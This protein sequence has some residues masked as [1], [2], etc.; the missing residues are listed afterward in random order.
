V[1]SDIVQEEVMEAKGVSYY[2]FP[3]LQ[4]KLYN[5]ILISVHKN[6]CLYLLHLPTDS[7]IHHVFL[8]SLLLWTDENSKHGPRRS[9]QMDDIWVLRKHFG[10]GV[11]LHF[12][13]CPGR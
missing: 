11:N 7:T 3:I 1:E 6:A 8:L 5:I 9:W 2:W 12:R 10:I 4:W 13:S